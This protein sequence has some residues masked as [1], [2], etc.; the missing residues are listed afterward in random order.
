MRAICISE[1]ARR[2][3]KAQSA[4]CLTADKVRLMVSGGYIFISIKPFWFKWRLHTLVVEYRNTQQLPSSHLGFLLC[5]TLLGNSAI[6]CAFE[7]CR[8]EICL[9]FV[10]RIYLKL[11]HLA[12]GGVICFGF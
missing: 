1:E 7:I 11:C 10:S 2:A 12:H 4:S 5:S 9:R 3:Q 8:L 6:A